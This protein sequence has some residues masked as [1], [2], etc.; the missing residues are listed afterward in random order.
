VEDSNSAKSMKD[1]RAAGALPDTREEA[2][3]RGLRAEEEK[4][5]AGGEPAL[6]EGPSTGDE[7]LETGSRAD[8]TSGGTLALEATGVIAAN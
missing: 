3:K 7:G 5:A 8:R 4:S 6:A 2:P 1:G